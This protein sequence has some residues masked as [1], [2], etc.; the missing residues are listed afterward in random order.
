MAVK[1]LDSV[2]RHGIAFKKLL[3]IV[4]L[5]AVRDPTQDTNAALCMLRTSAS[6]PSH[7]GSPPAPSGPSAPERPLHCPNRDKSTKINGGR[8]TPCSSARSRDGGVCAACCSMIWCGW[9]CHL[10]ALQCISA[11]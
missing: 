3:Q 6:R 2:V 9:E 11:V 10:I 5:S 1:L 7:W 4:R 8:S